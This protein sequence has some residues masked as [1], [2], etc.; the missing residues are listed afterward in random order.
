ME[1]AQLEK[2]RALLEEEKKK[3]WEGIHSINKT[4]MGESLRDSTGELSLCDN[5]PADIGSEVFERSKDYAL[6]ERAKLNIQAIDEALRRIEKGVYDIC[7][8]CGRRI[9]IER[10]EAVP[11]TTTCHDC[12]KHLEESAGQ[13]SRPVEEGV[14]MEVY[15][16]SYGGNVN[17]GGYDME[18]TWEDLVPYSENAGRSGAGA[19]YGEN[20]HDIEEERGIV[21]EVEGIPYEVGE[22]G[23][24]YKSYQNQSSDVGRRIRKNDLNIK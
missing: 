15:K 14:M 17:N 21:E 5:E 10:L 8:V 24:I 20:E 23:V 2:F 12:S 13:S 22:D 7:E 4:G 1:K 3:R 18:D 11:Y 16:K 9:P 19:Y 6:R